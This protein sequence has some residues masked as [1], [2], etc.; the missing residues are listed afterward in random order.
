MVVWTQWTKS[1]STRF[2]KR[3]LRRNTSIQEK[4]FVCKKIFLWMNSFFLID[5]AETRSNR[6]DLLSK[7]QF[8][9]S[10]ITICTSF[11]Q[12]SLCYIIGHGTI[13]TRK[14]SSSSLSH[15]R[16]DSHITHSFFALSIQLFSFAQW[17]DWC[18]FL[19]YLSDRTR[20]E[21]RS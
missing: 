15:D 1:I 21:Y 7:S 20:C 6:F 10:S 17:T 18:F 13:S 5:N 19:W 4:E 9:I 16:L 3:F 11:R 12:F 8:F 14:F 2:M